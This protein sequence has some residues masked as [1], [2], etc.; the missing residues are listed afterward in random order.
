MREVRSMPRRRVRP[1]RVGPVITTARAGAILVQP[2]S[3]E[4]GLGGAVLDWIRAHGTIASTC[5]IAP[6]TRP[7]LEALYA[8]TGA[9][10]A[11]WELKLALLARGPSLLVAVT[12]EDWSAMVRAKGPASPWQ[13]AP[14]TLREE[15]DAIGSVLSLLHVADSAE[16]AGADLARLAARPWGGPEPTPGAGVRSFA[17]ALAQAFATFGDARTAEACRAAAA[18]PRGPGRLAAVEAALG[19]ASVATPGSRL[20]AWRAWD[21]TT[22]PAT[23]SGLAAMGAAPDRWSSLVLSAGIHFFHRERGQN[24]R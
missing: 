2:D 14:G 10:N 6:F 22:A 3:F 19:E 11:G 9:W 20:A 21:D 16:V 5:W 1:L 18:V 8:G 24:A 15:L 4:L 17:A 13:H 12:T 23:L 7:D